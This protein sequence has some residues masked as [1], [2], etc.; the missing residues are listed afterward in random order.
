MSRDSVRWFSVLEEVRRQAARHLQAAGVELPERDGV[1]Y[2]VKEGMD[3]SSSL[4]PVGDSAAWQQLQ[5]LNAFQVLFFERPELEEFGHS[6]D[7]L[8]FFVLADPFI[9]DPKEPLLVRRKSDKLPQDLDI[10]G[11]LSE[12]IDW[13]KTTLLNFVIQTS[14]NLIVAS[15]WRE[16][17]KD[18]NAMDPTS[19]LPASVLRVAKHVYASPIR[20]AMNVDNSKAAAE[21]PTTSYPNV[22]FAVDNFDDAFNY[23]VLRESGWCYAVFLTAV[24]VRF[25]YS[26]C[27]HP[28]TSAGTDVDR[29]E[30][31]D[32]GTTMTPAVPSDMLD[33]LG[34]NFKSSEN[35]QNPL[36]G[37]ESTSSVAPSDACGVTSSTGASSS[38]HVGKGDHTGISELAERLKALG[39]E[40]TSIRHS[41]S[42][43]ADRR[44]PE[45]IELFSGFVTFEQLEQVTANRRR[46]RDR[47]PQLI[48]MRGPGGQGSADV[49]VT[50]IGPQL[51]ERS[52]KKGGKHALPR[53][54][55][56][57]K[58][59][60]VQHMFKSA[61]GAAASA[62]K[63]IVREAFDVLAGDD[64]APVG[65]Q[66]R[67]ALMNLSVPV[68]LLAARILQVPIGDQ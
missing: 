38:V 36:S 3:R 66:M 10:G 40:T 8:L 16:D 65:L 56:A 19:E 51:M 28:S 39:V 33:P 5:W 23:M 31:A 26:Q 41:S 11:M 44:V 52:A 50:C 43:A 2:D 25:P 17:L 48:R 62:A 37:L 9:K 67:C 30:D 29:G 20:M 18:V 6:T 47:S 64:D 53:V 60:P 14:Y 35:S 21:A 1:W 61:V 68:D 4:E 63:V 7:D 54:E 46:L 59:G 24:S 57:S 49:A 45:R 12:Q 27:Q 42:K 58:G 32:L 13:Y 15:C 34:A 55:I 22:C